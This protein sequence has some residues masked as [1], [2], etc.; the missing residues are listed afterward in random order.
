MSQSSSSQIAGGAR[1]RIVRA[2]AIILAV[3][4]AASAVYAQDKSAAEL[5]SQNGTR[6]IENA[7]GA[8]DSNNAPAAQPDSDQYDDETNPQAAADGGATFADMDQF[9]TNDDVYQSPIGALVQHNCVKLVTKQMACG[10]AV[11]EVRPGSPAAIA[12]MRP[13]SG[14]VHTLLGATVVGVAMVFPPAFAAIGLV[15]NNHVGEAFDLIIGVDGQRIHA[16]SD[17]QRAISEVRLGDVIYVTVVRQGKRLQ[18]PVR[19]TE[20]SAGAQ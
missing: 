1:T 4:L 14:L 19:F 11:L 10:L 6:V 7:A 16:I 3:M 2:A 20:Q 17:F 8:A 12:G 18:L 13:Y 15:D 9:V 5:D